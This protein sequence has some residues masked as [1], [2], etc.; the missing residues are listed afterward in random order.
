MGIANIGGAASPQVIYGKNS[1]GAALEP[2]DV[3]EINLVDGA[4]DG[5]E[6][7]TPD[8]DL[9]KPESLFARCGV[10]VAADGPIEIE[11]QDGANIAVQVEGP[12]SEVAV[13][14][15]SNNIAAGDLLI[16]QDGSSNLVKM[17]STAFGVPTALTD[18]S[19]GTA[20][21]TV[22]AVSGSGQD[23]EIN[24]NFASLT[25]Q[26][27]DL[28]NNIAALVDSLKVVAVARGA[29]SSADDTISAQIVKV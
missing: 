28:R 5:Y 12:V 26:V 27:N 13:D 14:G 20:G 16:K 23:T 3:V 25:D 22:V 11:F 9:S 15:N 6:F 18:S 29:S 10:V 7:T 4:G 8:I 21:S 19:G 1:T 24:N 17:L 2:G